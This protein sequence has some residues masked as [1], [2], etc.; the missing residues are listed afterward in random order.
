M[1]RSTEEK[2]REGDGGAGTAINFPLKTLRH[3]KE[4]GE[5]FKG[6]DFLVLLD[7]F[8]RVYRLFHS[9]PSFSFLP[10]LS[11]SFL[12]RFR[13]LFFLSGKKIVTAFAFY[14]LRH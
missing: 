11:L 14:S 13:V 6:E 7:P 1:H 10:N 3:E 5:F 4:E 9:S 8:L 2:G 12:F